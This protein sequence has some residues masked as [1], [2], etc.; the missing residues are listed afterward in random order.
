[1]ELL[2]SL[3]REQKESIVLLQVGTFLEYFDLLLYVHMAVLLNEIFFPKYD[4]F[5]TSIL[6]AATFC[7]TFVFRPIGALIL[8]RIGDRI[9]RKPTIVITTVMM[10]FSCIV[11]ANLP[12]YAQIGIT[13]AWI[14]IFCRIAQGISSMGEI[15]GAQIYL[16]ETIRPPARYPVTALLGISADL[17]GLFALGTAFFVISFGMNWRYAFWVGALIAAVGAFAR[18]RLRETPEF[19]EMTRKWMREQTHKTNLEG[20]ALT[21]T[22]EGALLNANWKEPIRGKTLM[23]Y[24]FISCGLPLCFYLAFIYF[25]PILKESFGYSPEDIIRH[26]FFLMLV[27]FI[28]NIFITYLSCRIHPLKINQARA[29][30]GLFLMVSLPFLLMNLTSI[31][32]LFLIQSLIV[33]M[34]LNDMPSFAVFL[35]HFPLYRRVTFASFLWSVSRALMYIITSFGLVFLGNYFG[36]FGLWIITL[37]TTC[38]FLYGINHFKQLERKRRLYNKSIPPI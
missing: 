12:T 6:T 29:I 16:T 20:D 34:A 1:M 17:G 23:S 11:M 26:N 4:P 35:S 33:I 27:T 24:F 28:I 19:L 8:G 37:P 32:Q 13:A 31:V 7:S 18:V 21:G 9:G 30:S 3:N 2:S 36:H 14:M 25:N 15:V 38:A 5:T 10:A 22:N